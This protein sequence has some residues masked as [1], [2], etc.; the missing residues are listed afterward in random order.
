VNGRYAGT[1]GTEVAFSSSGSSGS[2]GAIASYSW[3]FGD[4][5]TSTQANPSH[6]FAAAGSYT[7]TLKV[8]D[9]QSATAIAVTTATISSA[10]AAATPASSAAAP[11]AAASAGTAAP[12]MAEF[13]DVGEMTVNQDWSCVEFTKPFSEPVIV[14]GPLSG[15]DDGPAVVRVEVNPAECSFGENG[16]FR[17]RVQEW[18]YL[19]GSHPDETV[20]YLVMERGSHR[21]SDGTLVEAG[22]LE[23]DKT[24]AYM[25]ADF[26]APFPEGVNPVVLAA[27]TT[28]NEADAVTTRVRNIDSSGFETGMQEQEKNAPQH[29]SE[30]IDYIAWEPSAG[31]IDGI[32]FE[33]GRTSDVVTDSPYSGLDHRLA[34]NH[35]LQT[36]YRL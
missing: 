17:I 3:S 18:D 31:A 16:G 5:A 29:A 21:L 7:V 10:S 8:T 19:D 2:A 9:D 12:A 28:T 27:V 6:S 20:S 22:R 32:S 1:V 30:S 34:Q 26:E 23:T 25:R 13:L 11:A 33:V 24:N 4:G 35:A 36:G 14:P 15:N